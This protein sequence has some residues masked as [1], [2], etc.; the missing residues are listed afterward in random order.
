LAIRTCDRDF[1]SRLEITEVVIADPE[2][3]AMIIKFIVTMLRSEFI[4]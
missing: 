3:Q 4:D 2:K 1:V